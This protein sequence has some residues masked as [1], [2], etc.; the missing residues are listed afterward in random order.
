MDRVTP[1]RLYLLVLVT[2]LV[3]VHGV[4]PDSFT[5][6]GITV[7]LV[8]ILVVIVLVP[9]LESA[10]LPGGTGLQFR[11]RLDEL[12]Q[13]SDKATEEQES[14][15]PVTLRPPTEVAES[16]LGLGRLHH[17]TPSG[18]KF[19]PS[20]RSTE[21][22]VDEV[23]QE[24]SRSPRV[25]L[26]LLSAELDRA[27]RDILVTTGWATPTSA[28]S[29]RLGIERL[30]E[31]GVLTRSGSSALGLFVD[32]RNE[33]VHGGRAIEDSQILRAID[34][35]I[36]L[37]R[38]IL[39]IARERNTVAHVNVTLYADENGEVPVDRGHGIILETLSPGSATVSYRIFPTMRDDY[40]VGKEVTW[41]WNMDRRWARTWYRDPD[42]G[43][44]RHAW[45]GSGE[46]VGRHLDEV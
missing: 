42:S 7:G 16:A 19:T 14:G 1:A 29:L 28:R 44:V 24:A 23:L 45:D 12:K 37:L 4:A 11:K 33:I 20:Q 3:V 30:V 36:P 32:V 35:G 21:E 22:I 38:S 27:V 26:M 43:D 10:S 6:D 9:L 34:A 25:G 17:P 41:E 39:A 8:G 31:L 40:S 13:E 18:A 15:T 5:V 46:F 2:V